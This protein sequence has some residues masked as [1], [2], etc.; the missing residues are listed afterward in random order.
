[1]CVPGIFNFEFLVYNG[2]RGDEYKHQS[3]TE[4]LH[5][6]KQAIVMII[7]LPFQVLSLQ[8]IRKN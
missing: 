7:S 3:I 4:E 8:S 5:F 2:K 6:L 1:M